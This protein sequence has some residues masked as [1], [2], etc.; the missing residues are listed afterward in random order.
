MKGQQNQIRNTKSQVRSS[1]TAQC[2]LGY[3]LGTLLALGLLVS[4]A[5]L[6]LEGVIGQN[7]EEIKV[8]MKS[9]EPLSKG[10]KKEPAQSVRKV[11]SLTV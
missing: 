3:W 4:F 11:A 7:R 2:E 9:S 5:G 1:L 6:H 8:R 10:E